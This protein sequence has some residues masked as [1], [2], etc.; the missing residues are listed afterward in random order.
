MFP[1]LNLAAEKAAELFERSAKRTMNYSVNIHLGMSL[2][3]R[4]QFFDHGLL[5]SLAL[6]K[7]E[8][9]CVFILL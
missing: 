4:Q 7:R 5:S 2:H 8:L 6:L 1:L 9:W 3:H